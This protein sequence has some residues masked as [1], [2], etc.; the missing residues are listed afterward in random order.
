M[1]ESRLKKANELC[2]TLNKCDE[3]KSLGGD[4]EL[5]KLEGII[6]TAQNVDYNVKKTGMDEFDTIGLG[7]YRTNSDFK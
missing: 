1:K 4:S 6:H 2:E 7:K 5:K 3:F